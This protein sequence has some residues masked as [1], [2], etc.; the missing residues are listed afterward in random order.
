MK[1]T[2]LFWNSI[3]YIS[4]LVKENMPLLTAPHAGSD[5]SFFGTYYVAVDGC[6]P[7]GRMPEPAPESN[8]EEPRLEGVDAK[9]VPKSFRHCAGTMNVSGNHDLL[10]VTSPD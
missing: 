10:K 7:K 9:G 5:R 6:G 2:R 4:K 1:E 8:A 3:E